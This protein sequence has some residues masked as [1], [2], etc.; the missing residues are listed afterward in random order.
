MNIIDKIIQRIKKREQEKLDK[1]GELI[2][3]NGYWHVD[4]FSYGVF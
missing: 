2:V 4:E 1:Y 3:K